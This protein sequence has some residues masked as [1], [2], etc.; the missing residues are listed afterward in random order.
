MSENPVASQRKPGFTV[1]SFWRAL[2]RHLFCECSGCSNGGHSDMINE[3]I[4]YPTSKFGACNPVQ[5]VGLNGNSWWYNSLSHHDKTQCHFGVE[6]E[7]EKGIL[8]DLQQDYELY[9]V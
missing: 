3:C 5:E 1:S 6:L 4:E 9:R 7:Y 2:T 8:Y